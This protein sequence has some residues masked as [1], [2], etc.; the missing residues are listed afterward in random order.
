MNKAGTQSSI[1]V[2]CL[3]STKVGD[4]DQRVSVTHVGAHVTPTICLLLDCFSQI[5]A[6]NALGLCEAAMRLNCRMCPVIIYWATFN[7][8]VWLMSDL[9]F[10]EW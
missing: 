6:R 1:A 3:R 4:S 5:H 8:S 7:P 10:F 2:W 9:Q